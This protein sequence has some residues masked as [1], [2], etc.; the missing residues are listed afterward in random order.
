[1]PNARSMPTAFW[2]MILGALFISL[3]L[4]FFMGLVLIAV[5]GREVPA[6]SRY[7]VVIVVAFGA[8]IGGGFLGGGAAADGRLPLPWAEK[9]PIQFSLYGGTAFFLIVLTLGNWL[10]AARVPQVAK[11][12]VNVAQTLPGGAEL[13][14]Q[15]DFERQDLPAGC[16]GHLELSGDSDFQNVW[17]KSAPIERFDSGRAI[18]GVPNPLVRDGWLRIVITDAA[19]TTISRSDP[20][21]FRHPQDQETQP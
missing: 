8:A 17:Y 7:L 18:I 20:V 9:H 4:L 19:G 2:A 21:A 13:R 5:Y 3:T 14:L 12:R 1:M 11:P 6:T 10:F 15:I 16:R